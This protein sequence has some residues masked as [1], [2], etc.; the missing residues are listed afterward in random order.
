MYHS[1]LIHSSADGHLGCFHVLAMINSS[2][3]IS[4]EGLENPQSCS[5]ASA[6][7][8]LRVT[9][10]LTRTWETLRYFRS[11]LSPGWPLCHCSSCFKRPSVW[12]TLSL[13]AMV[14]P[15]LLSSHLG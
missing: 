5:R 9:G 3:S 1:F 14:G 13:S 7:L 8:S 2:A 6:L 12:E 15:G 4:D 10:T 11:S